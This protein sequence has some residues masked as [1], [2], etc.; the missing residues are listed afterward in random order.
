MRS[1]R[2]S[3]L[4]SALNS[5]TRT[6]HTRVILSA[7]R[8]HLL[9]ATHLVA[10]PAHRLDHAIAGIRVQIA[11]TKFLP[12]I[13]HV[14]IHH[15]GS[16]GGRHLPNLSQQLRPAAATAAP[17]QQKPQQ[18]KLLHGK[19]HQSPIPR[20]PALH[21]IQFHIAMSQHRIGKLLPPPQQ[22]PATRRQFMK[23][24]R[25]QQTIIRSQIQTLHSF[26]HLAPSSQHQHRSLVEPPVQFRQHLRPVLPRQAQIEHDQIRTMLFRIL[27]RRLAIS[28]PSHIMALKLQSLL[29][30]Q[31][32]RRIIFHN[33]NS[34]FGS[35]KAF[36]SLQFVHP[37]DVTLPMR[38]ACYY[39]GAWSA[40]IQVLFAFF[41]A[42]NFKMG[43]SRTKPY[44]DLSSRARVGA[45][46]ADTSIAIRSIAPGKRGG[47][48]AT[49]TRH[50]LPTCI[51]QIGTCTASPVNQ[52]PNS[53]RNK[54]L[55]IR[56][57]FATISAWQSRGGKKRSST[58][59]PTSPR[60]TATPLPMRRSPAAWASARSPPCI[61]TSRT[62]RTRA[63]CSAPTTAAG[64][65]TY[66][67]SA[68]AKEALIGCLSWAASPPANPSKPSKPQRASR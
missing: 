27:Q 1:T 11:R 32:Q 56:F 63:S 53:R 5:R 39:L 47:R 68:P 46:L 36:S 35:P 18:G 30:K 16:S 49:A 61:N 14:H 66:S 65:S 37:S 9:R 20:H 4:V 52:Q 23:A 15:I 7:T 42:P 12:Q 29:K 62:S 10:L 13:I 55:A 8:H 50:H 33:K 44:T 25:L 24:E 57:L 28:Y 60:R 54:L 67:P 26:L 38:V 41:C 21:A 22:R 48:G 3:P 2:A 6:R 45:P 17:H 51:A 58:S 19:L 43:I 31:P 59:F 40:A 64:P 34:H